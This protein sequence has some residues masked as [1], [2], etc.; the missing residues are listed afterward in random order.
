MSRG[1][2]KLA[3]PPADEH[4]DER[5]AVPYGDMLTVLMCLFIVLFAMSSVDQGKFEKLKESLATGF[6]TETS[7]TVDAAEGVVVPPELVNSEAAGFTDM[8]LAM[9]EVAELR[10]LEDAVAKELASKGLSETVRFVTDERGLTVRMMSTEAFFNPNVATLTDEAAQVLSSVAPVLSGSGRDIG[11]EGHTQAI[12]YT[13]PYMTGW[14][15]SSA[16]SVNVVRYLVENGA[17]KPEKITPSG[18]GESRPLTPG[19]TEEEKRLN[20]RTDIVIASDEADRVKALIPEAAAK[21]DAGEHGA[22]P[23]A[24][25]GGH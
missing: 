22:A 2:R 15:L 9:Q 8:D 4:M 21:V 14:E 24:K 13:Y 18:F 23:E 6:G 17:V 7:E 5:W 12:P 1:R 25:G 11:V 16:R 19:N 20:R 10:A 3:G